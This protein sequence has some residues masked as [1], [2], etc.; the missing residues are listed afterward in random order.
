MA[1]TVLGGEADKYPGLE[2]SPDVCRISPFSGRSAR[3]KSAGHL[4]DEMDQKRAVDDDAALLAVHTPKFGG[5]YRSRSGSNRGHWRPLFLPPSGVFRVCVRTW[6]ALAP[7]QPVVTMARRRKNRTHLKGGP[8]SAPGSAE[9]VPKSFVIK[10]GQVGHSLT[11]LVRD[12]R[13]VM[14]P[15]TASRLRVSSF[16]NHLVILF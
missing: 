8:A 12:M 1:L 6:T 13:K 16:L 4:E 2:S 5:S 7:L 11:Q 15:N 14:E 10:H 9:G 3:R